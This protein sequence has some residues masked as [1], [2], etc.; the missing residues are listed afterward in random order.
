MNRNFQFVYVCMYACRIFLIWNCNAIA[1]VCHSN[2][3]SWKNISIYNNL[4]K[5]CKMIYAGDLGNKGVF[6]FLFTIN[7][8][9]YYY[10]SY[11]Y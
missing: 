3:L 2:S 1:F 9:C 4:M 10:Y 5:S 8:I 6:I 11:I 7:K